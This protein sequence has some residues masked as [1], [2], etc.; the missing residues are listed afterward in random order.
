MKCHSSF[1]IFEKAVKCF[2][3]RLLQI[4][5]GALRVNI[6]SSCAY[7]VCECPSE[8]L[9]YIQDG[10]TCPDPILKEGLQ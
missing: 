10:F 2:N 1:V 4:I 6:G 3:C 5:G 8:L 9:Y 7:S